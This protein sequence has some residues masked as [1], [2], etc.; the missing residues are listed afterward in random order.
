MASPVLIPTSSLIGLTPPEVDA[1]RERYGTNIVPDPSTDWRLLKDI[2]TEPMFGLLAGAC[3]IYGFLGEWREGVALGIAMLLV[4]ALSVYETLRSDRAMQVL[5][6]LTQATVQVLRTSQLISLPT[7]QLVVGDVVLLTEGQTIPADGVLLQANDCS[8]DEA[9]LTGESVP[10][11]K[12]EAGT[13]CFGGTVITSGRIYIRI[14]AVGVNTEL[15]KLGRSLQ[16]IMVEKTPL[17]QEIHQFVNRMAL[18]GLSAFLLVWA[19]N[20]AHSGDWVTSLLFGLTMAMTILPEEIPVAFSSF[21]ALGA[22]R[23]AKFGVLT[24]Q[25]QTVESLGSASVIC[26]DKTGTITQEGMS[27]VQLYIGSEQRIVPLSEVISA[28]AWDVLACAR[29]ASEPE[30]FDA[31]EQAI[32]T[33]YRTHH[34]PGDSCQRPLVHEYPLSGTP[35]M[36]THVYDPKAGTVQVA[37]KGAVERIIR[38]CRLTKP[39]AAIILQ[40]ANQL[41]AEGFRVLGVASSEWVGATYPTDQDDFT[42]SFIGL[43]AFENPPKPNARWVIDQFKQAGIAVKLITGDS[44][45]TALSIAR[46]VGLTDDNQVLTGVQVMLLSDEALRKQVGSIRVFA[47]MLPQAKLRVIEALKANGQIVA[48]TGDGVNDG[49]ALK[50]AHI[51]VAMG[52]RGTELAKQ[53]ASLILSKDD[54]ASMVEAIALGRRIYQNLKKAVAYIISIHIPIIL[55]VTLPLLVNWQYANLLSPIHIIL[56]ELIMGPTCS[57][58]FEQEPAEKG[59]MHQPPRPLSTTFLTA[60]ELGM[61]I[62]Q[63]L[64]IALATLMVY[65]FGMQQGQ[66]IET[67]RTITFS[68]LVLSN[69]G[70][71]LVSRSNRDSLLQTLKKNNPVLWSVLGITVFILAVSLFVPAIRSFMQFAPLSRVQLGQCLLA[72]FAGTFWVEVYKWRKR[73]TEQTVSYTI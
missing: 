54:L 22:A 71:T 14:N 3:A 20:F 68:T 36:M 23:M 57:I 61:S 25:P 48:M 27:L 42:W 34:P 65:Y 40:Q 6:Q 69:I 10:L 19:V 46:Q 24:K 49:P 51:G 5:R 32:L 18:I 15:G 59:L 17:Q 31:M 63:G 4:A 7:E 39:E 64:L 52:Q 72:S 9:M 26:V 8:V 33:A 11:P 58:A 38:V 28:A 44:P 45:E 1:S 2:I 13:P 73:E 21:M 62:I 47:R 56:L 41:A 55:I 43:L 16:A 53:A 30:P 12:T 37:G 67:V 70:L 60:N 35:P 50:A 29:W 66:S